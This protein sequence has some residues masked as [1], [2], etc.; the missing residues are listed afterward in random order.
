MLILNGLDRCRVSALLLLTGLFQDWA[1]A[2]RWLG[3]RCGSRRRAAG[4]R[5]HENPAFGIGLLE[6]ALGFELCAAGVVVGLFGFAIFIDGAL[7]L[8]QEIENF[9]EIDV[10]PDLGPLFRRFGDGLQ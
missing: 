10:A 3:R 9:A 7:A 6:I 4:R 5:G 1:V 2:C 8:T